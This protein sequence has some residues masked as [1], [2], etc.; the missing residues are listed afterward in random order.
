MTQH[1]GDTIPNT[2]RIQA[3]YDISESGLEFTGGVPLPA[4]AYVKY[5]TPKSNGR[6]WDNALEVVLRREQPAQ[7]P[8]D[9]MKMN[10]TR[11]AQTMALICVYVAQYLDYISDEVDRNTRFK[12]YLNQL[13]QGYEN[14]GDAGVTWS[15]DCEDTGM[16][17]AATFDS[18]AEATLEGS[19]YKDVFKHMQQKVMPYYIPLMS[20]D[21][22]HGA[23]VSD[24]T[25]QV[26][27]HLNTMFV[28]THYFKR[29]LEK[30]KSGRAISK[31]VHWPSLE[32]HKK[33][34]W[35]TLTGEG[36]GMYGPLGL[37]AE[38]HEVDAIAKQRALVYGMPSLDG[39][40]KDLVHE[41]GTP[42]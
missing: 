42:S 22:V 40:K 36:T 3:P 31:K 2:E 24:D 8:E 18:L 23:K 30:S 32:A 37:L 16:M 9:Y 21:V 12:R 6:F 15:G 4:M 29:C 1:V 20:L 17:I 13:K 35:P 28:P 27:A 34:D 19:R 39:F 10:H 11:Q 38:E 14:F 26:G 25:E 33:E 7:R 41:H 5:E